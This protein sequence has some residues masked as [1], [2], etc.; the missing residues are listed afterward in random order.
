M[1]NKI[2]KNLKPILITI[3]IL[4]SISLLFL[5]LSEENSA[6]ANY[7][8]SKLFDFGEQEHLKE[9]Y[10][11]NVISVINYEEK[12]S[13]ISL[14]FNRVL[15]I[16]AKMSLLKDLNEVVSKSNDL[17]KINS[18]QSFTIPMQA[19]YT[20]LEFE[21]YDLH[22]LNNYINNQETLESVKYYV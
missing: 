16:N 13:P 11:I 14:V 3:G 8:C 10:K 6:T 5:L 20:S 4:F 9:D 1:N 17:H 2:K 19:C 21:T 7:Q 15:A 18:E 22:T 12:I